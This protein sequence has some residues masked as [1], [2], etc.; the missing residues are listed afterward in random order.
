MFSRGEVAAGAHWQRQEEEEEALM[1]VELMEGYSNV[2]EEQLELESGQEEVEALTPI[3]EL[4]GG[5]DKDEDG[6][7]SAGEGG[8]V[9]CVCGS[10][11][12]DPLMLR[13]AHCR[14]LQHGACYRVVAPA[15]A[16]HCCLGCS[17]EGRRCT[18]PYMGALAR[19]PGLTFELRRALAILLTSATF[20]RAS[21]TSHLGLVGCR[22]DNLAEKL[23]RMGAYR[24]DLTVDHGVVEQLIAQFLGVREARRVG[25]AEVQV[26]DYV[27][28]QVEDQG[29]EDVERMDVEERVEEEVQAERRKEVN[30]SVLYMASVPLRKAKEVEQMTERPMVKVEEEVG[31]G[32]EC[33]VCA[34]EGRGRVGRCTTD[35]GVAAHG[36][37]HWPQVLPRAGGMVYRVFFFTGPP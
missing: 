25:A 3:D 19:H 6:Q 2:V 5:D 29:P 13:C 32:V 30:V 21:L 34:E 11:T 15:P 1:Q 28:N 7:A 24:A 9:Q 10:P 36:G 27:E 8:E 12:A 26:E 33:V 14:Q 22:A 20:P 23:G 31:V 17:G 4:L 18:D 16:R 37:K 35:A